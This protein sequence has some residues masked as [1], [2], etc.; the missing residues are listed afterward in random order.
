M[1]SQLPIAPS[2][3]LQCQSSSRAGLQGWLAQTCHKP[4]G[5]QA[6][7][8]SLQAGCGLLGRSRRERVQT[9]A[10]GPSRLESGVLDGG[11]AFLRHLHKSG[12]M[13]FDQIFKQQ[14]LIISKC[15]T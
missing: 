9:E 4:S 7:A 3:V 12:I 10:A 11:I 6:L 2:P 5:S 14:H 8:F 15:D 13:Y 1:I